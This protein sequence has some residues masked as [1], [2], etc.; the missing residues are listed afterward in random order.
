MTPAG[1]D[2]RPPGMLHLNGA[3]FMYCCGTVL[4]FSAVDTTFRA[5]PVIAHFQ[6]GSLGRIWC[7]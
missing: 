7:V 1:Y 2:D 6:D 4:Q 5:A 3:S